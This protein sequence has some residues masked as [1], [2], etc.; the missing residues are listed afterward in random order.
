MGRNKSE[1]RPFGLSRFDRPMDEMFDRFWRTFSTPWMEEGPA[2]DLIDRKDELVLRADLPGLNKEDVQIDVHDSTLVLRGKR[3]EE[4][5]EKE[6][7]YFYAERW[8]GSFTRSIDLPPQVEADKVNATFK[9]G[10][11]EVHLP[12]ARE[13]KGK[14]IEI[15][16]Q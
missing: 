8:S 16:A 1:E 3:S 9:N 6:G 12:K 7:E 15:R 11:L 10:V 4:R 5:E 14:K 2:L 13:A